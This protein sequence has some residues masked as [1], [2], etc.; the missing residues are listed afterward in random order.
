MISTT[1]EAQPRTTALKI[2]HINPRGIARPRG[3]THVV[4]GTGGRTIHISGRVSLDTAG[5]LIGKGE[6][7]AQVG[8]VFANL[9]IALMAT[10]AGPKDVVKTNMYVV[11]MKPDD[12]PV[13]RESRSAFF[14]EV[15][16]PASPWWGS[17]RSPSPTTSSRSRRSRSWTREQPRFWFDE[18]H[19][20]LETRGLHVERLF[21]DA[22]TAYKARV[23]RWL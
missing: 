7:K 11:N 12:V 13:I 18:P 9:K 10:G 8:Q 20:F 6:L 3:Y 2:D 23:P 1:A 5:A 21:G 16:P 4:S 14:S 22:Y 15:E 19:R 17:R